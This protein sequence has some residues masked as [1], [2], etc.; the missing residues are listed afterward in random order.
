LVAALA[1]L[2]LEALESRNAWDY[3]IDPF[4]WLLSLGMLGAILLR[5]VRRRRASGAAAA[6]LP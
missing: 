3:V 1:A 6:G 5:S 4:Y 2:G